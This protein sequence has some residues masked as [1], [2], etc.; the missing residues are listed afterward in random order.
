MKII[1][2]AEMKEL[3]RMTI[4][5]CGM[6]G[7]WLMERAGLG[8]ARAV[9]YL[10]DL[11][12]YS[13]L[14][15]CIFAGRGNNGGDAFVVARYMKEW[16]ADVRVWLTCERS[17]VQGDAKS[18]LIRLLALGVSVEEFVEV[19]DFEMLA[20][21]GLDCGIVVDGVLGIGIKGPA[22]GVAAAAI[23]CIN[24]L[25]TNSP[26][27]AIDI[28]SGMDADTGEAGGDV[29]CSDLT[30]TMAYPKT[31]LAM[32]IAYDFVGSVDVVDIGV[33]ASFAEKIDA[34]LDLVTASDLYDVCPVRSRSAHKGD[35]G[36]V[37]LIGGAPG[38][39]GAIALA[40]GAALRSGCGLVTV[41]TSTE[42][43]PI[44]ASIVPEA[45]VHGVA[46][47]DFLKKMEELPEFDAILAGPGMTTSSDTKD[48]LTALLAMNGAPL[49]LDADALNIFSAN[50][51]ALLGAKRE[52]VI[53]PH[54]GE[55]ARLLDCTA[56][57]IQSDRL[58]YAR[59]LEKV[60]GAIV[61]LKGA[62]SLIAGK[63]ERCSIN[64]TGNPGMATGGSGDVL[65]GLLVGLLG[66][67]IEPYNAAKLAVYLHGS[68]GDEAAWSSSQGGMKAGDIIQAI[69]MAFRRVVTR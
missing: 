50:G 68:A 18:H 9:E 65:A 60:T 62:G 28:P 40:A 22:R 49:V 67:H 30:V 38:Y 14:P 12:G 13:R 44:V 27:V 48:L 24:S 64:L 26:V 34:P 1:S 53:T 19:S 20:A 33:P 25:G 5:E 8:V 63:G 46:P 41:L 6:P 23:R 36:H 15:V 37:L 35:F 16:G 54:P 3:D 2:S 58:K 7:E 29:V 43:A 51:K 47:S 42:T 55:A 57:E 39:A 52:V 10:S 69:P 31:G 21:S 4:A 45:M 11:S 32:P 61:V 66:Q 17:A 59:E 56:V